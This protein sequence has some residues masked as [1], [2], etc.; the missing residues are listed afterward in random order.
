MVPV[1]FSEASLKALNAARISGIALNSSSVTRQFRSAGASRL[2][3][4]DR[5]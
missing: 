5:C 3:R 1:D 2:H 4:R